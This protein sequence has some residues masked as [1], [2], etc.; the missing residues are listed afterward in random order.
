M[1][2]AGQ[3]ESVFSSLAMLLGSV[4][5]GCAEGIVYLWLLFFLTV[6]CVPFLSCPACQ[7]RMDFV[8]GLL[9]VFIEKCQSFVFCFLEKSKRKLSGSLE[10][11]GWMGN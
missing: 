9:S 11:V 4:E 2:T 3:P 10:K 6:T 1:A 5:R 7:E 8:F